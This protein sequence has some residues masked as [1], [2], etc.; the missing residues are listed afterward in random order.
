MAK[1]GRGIPIVLIIILIFLI[2]GSLVIGFNIGGIRDIVFSIIGKDIAK[3]IVGGLQ[4]QDPYQDEKEFIN[5]EK[6]KLLALRTDLE[7][8]R[9]QLQDKENELQEKET[10]LLE[11]ER[12]IERL[13]ERLSVQY[14]D[15]TELTKIYEKMDGEEAAAILSQIEDTHQVILIIKNLRKEKSAEILG[16]MDAKIAADILSEMY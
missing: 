15:L 16:L 13:S 14:E 10:L 1:R 2:S 11:K 4:D 12:E 9:A 7:N 3:D 5:T 6:A 8:Y